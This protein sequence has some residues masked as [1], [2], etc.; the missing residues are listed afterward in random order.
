[1]I[2]TVAADDGEGSQARKRRKVI[3]ACKVCR[4]KK[5]RCDGKRPACSSCDNRGV[6]CE[7]DDVAVPLPT[8]SSL[9]ELEARVAR[10]ESQQSSQRILPVA[11]GILVLRYQ[12]R[13]M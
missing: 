4:A 2:L 3:V 1:M 8:I 12:S 10:L 11:G 6:A 13:L 7:Y 9:S 5:S